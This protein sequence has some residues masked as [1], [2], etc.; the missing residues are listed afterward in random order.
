MIVYP[1][2][3]H[4]HIHQAS[5][6]TFAARAPPSTRGSLTSTGNAFAQTGGLRA[7]RIDAAQWASLDRGGDLDATKGGAGPNSLIVPG[8]GF[9]L[10]KQRVDTLL[11]DMLGNRMRIL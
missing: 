7:L 1:F 11:V 2:H 3:E 9:K 8:G 6:L 5:D 10:T 4:A